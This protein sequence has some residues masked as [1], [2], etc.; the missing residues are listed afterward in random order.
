[1]YFRKY[2]YKELS[3]SDCL[4]TLLHQFD[5]RTEKLQEAGGGIIPIGMSGRT[6]IICRGE[7]ET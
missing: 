6:W 3:V 2:V 4:D 1:M 7:N 5:A